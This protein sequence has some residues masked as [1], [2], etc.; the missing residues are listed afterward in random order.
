MSRG[1]NNCFCSREKGNR[2]ETPRSAATDKTPCIIPRHFQPEIYVR[3]DRTS[4]SR[5][6]RLEE[7]ERTK[8]IRKAGRVS[9]CST[10]FHLC[11]FSFLFRLNKKL[12][13]K[14]TVCFNLRIR[15]FPFLSV[16]FLLLSFSFLLFPVFEGNGIWVK[17]QVWFLGS[18]IF[19]S[20]TVLEFPVSQALNVPKILNVLKKMRCHE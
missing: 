18:G 16:S 14:G 13:H 5:D 4:T 12:P 2:G 6:W 11:S 20:V 9:L 17:L 1:K 3:V 19:N 7:Q 15:A 8:R 10:R